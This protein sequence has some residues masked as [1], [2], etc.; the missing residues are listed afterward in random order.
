MIPELRKQFNQRW[1]PAKYAE[2]L[3]LLA[4]DSA[5]PMQFRCNETPVFLPTDLLEKMIRYGQELYAQLAAN[6][7]YSKLADATI[8]AQFKVPNEDPHPLFVQADFGLVR[9]E[10]GN[11]EPKL[12]E[13]QGFPSAYAMQPSIARQYRRVYDIHDHLTSFLGGL[14]ES[15]YAALLKEAIVGKHDPKEVILLEVDPYSQKTLPDFILTAKQTG[16]RIADIAHVKKEGRQL[17]FEGVPVK[18]IYNRV[19]VDELVRRNVETGFNFN[20]DL[21][22]EWAG[23][24]NW[25]FKLSKFSLPFFNHE[26]VPATWFLRDL[27]PLPENL[28]EYVLKPLFSF[29]G[30]GVN[31]SPTADDIAAI[32]EAQRDQYILQ[33]K[34]N[35]VPT[36]ETP[37]GP[38]K[39]EIRIMYIRD[40][41][42]LRAVTTL[43]RTG[44]GKMMG[45]D[46]NKGLE[47]T[48]ASAGFN[49]KPR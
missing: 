24:P 4:H 11:L 6:P 21:D 17:F 42:E 2:F 35:F 18:R 28:E 41:E 39:V 1:T 33:R 34:M 45:V 36:L 19:I 9:G 13:I 23:H 37:H 14:R 10:D 8:P 32:P 5:G 46:F 15:A 48:G 12:V 30:M 38:T 27:K 22:V 44:R 40:G 3:A 26:C 31:I 7:E 43:L 16:I 25:F 29:A 49:W 20:D 47:W